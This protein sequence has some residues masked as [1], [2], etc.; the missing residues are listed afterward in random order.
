VMTEHLSTLG[1][2]LSTLCFAR[3][4]RTGRIGDALAFSAIAAVAILTHANAW[5]LG[6]V[7]GITVALTNRWDMHMSVES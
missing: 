3:F 2:L 6:L 7:P 4:A 1:M 5:A